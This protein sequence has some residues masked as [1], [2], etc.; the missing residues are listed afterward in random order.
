MW[1]KNLKKLKH[2]EN[3]SYLYVNKQVANKRID[4]TLIERAKQLNQV[5]R[6]CRICPIELILIHIALGKD[7]VLNEQKNIDF[8]KVL[9]RK[10]SF[11][12]NRIFI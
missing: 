9:I 12:K 2:F 8:T 6:V 1:G 7:S 11:E 3:N 10:A 5:C 4:L